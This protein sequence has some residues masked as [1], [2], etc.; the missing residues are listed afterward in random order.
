MNGVGHGLGDFTPG[1][2]LGL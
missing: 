1:L 2:G